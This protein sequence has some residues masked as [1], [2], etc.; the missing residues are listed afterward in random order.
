LRSW[1]LKLCIKV[2]GN[3]ILSSHVFLFLFLIIIG[4]SKTYLAHLD[5]KVKKQLVIC[6]VCVHDHS[7]LEE[8]SLL[9]QSLLTLPFFHHLPIL[10]K[11]LENILKTLVKKLRDFFFIID[12]QNYVV[13]DFFMFSYIFTINISFLTNFL[14]ILISKIIFIIRSKNSGDVLK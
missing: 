6:L 3:W 2:K 7:T 13:Y 1:S 10:Y 12:E 8:R 9:Q 14:R 5:K 11:A 4:L